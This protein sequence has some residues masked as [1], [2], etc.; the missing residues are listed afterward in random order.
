LRE[1][2]D[3]ETVFYGR[4]IMQPDVIAYEKVCQG[5]A[6]GKQSVFS[7]GMLSARTK[8]PANTMK[9]IINVVDR[10]TA[11]CAFFDIELSVRPIDDVVID[12][13]QRDP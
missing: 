9:K 1:Q 11:I 12:I 7:P 2:E 10:A 8:Y 6:Q 13:I 3:S 5:G 4:Y